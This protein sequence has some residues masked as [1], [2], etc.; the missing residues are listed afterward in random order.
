MEIKMAQ[1]K[2]ALKMT[3]R[4]KLV[5]IFIAL[6]LVPMFF[7]SFLTFFCAHRTLT[8]TQL[9]LIW[10]L[11]LFAL[12]L[13]E[14]ATVAIVRAI[15]N[16]RDELNKEIAE[17]KKTEAELVEYHEHLE[18]LVKDRTMKLEL[19][20]ES[21]DKTKKDAEAANHAKSI[22]LANMSHEIR[23]PMNAVLGYAQLL[24]RDS[25]LKDEQREFVKIISHSG[26]HLLKLINEILEISKI[27]A[28][29]ATLNEEDFDLRVL[30]N[31]A[32][33]MFKALAGEKNLLLEINISKNFP[34][35]IHADSGKIR[36]IIMNLLSNAIKF[37]EKGG[38]TIRAYYRS[39]SPQI[40][41]DNICIEVND[42][43]FGIAASE[44]GKIFNA[45]EQG[46]DA[47]LKGKG[48]GLGL[49]I[50][51][52]YAKMMGGNITVSSQFGKGSTFCL[53]FP[54]KTCAIEALEKNRL[55]AKKIIGLAK[56]EKVPKVLV[57]DDDA[58]SRDVLRLLL[59]SVGFV[60]AEAVNGKEAIILAQNWQ[61]DVILMDIV[62]PEING[63]E[64]MQILKTS[65]KTK[66]MPVIVIT[67][68]PFEEEHQNAIKAGSAGFIRKP[69]IEAEVFEEIRKLLRISYIYAA[70][71]SLKE[72]DEII[73]ITPDDIAKLSKQLILEII[74]AAEAGD[75]SK[76]QKIIEIAVAPLSSE[77]GKKLQK[78]LDNYNYEKIVQLLRQ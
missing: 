60:V 75:S 61:P 33:T 13:G 26:D 10:F 36:Q 72:T 64:A 52:H 59:T 11:I 9:S 22:F 74:E 58:P 20:M 50:S 16:S 47:R 23:T 57:A 28:G 24:L 78:F 30:I 67:A 40:V 68:S 69:F 65:A 77:V 8:N 66:E 44:I 37:T 12:T 62:M 5:I 1:Y 32:E 54:A 6:I 29:C 70:Q 34:A 17:R 18:Q 53:T 76:L 4:N 73:T 49:T 14:L 38:V 46:P 7:V 71:V 63:I 15:L 56:N 45:F 55:S 43:G 25:T 35:C 41:S 19:A 39:S 42:T 48:T 3:I 31:D 21:L 51:L 27:E 2:A